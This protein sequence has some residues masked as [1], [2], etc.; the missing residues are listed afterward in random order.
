MPALTTLSILLLKL[1]NSSWLMPDMKSDFYLSFCISLDSFLVSV[2]VSTFESVS[3]SVLL[4][5]FVF[6]LCLTRF[7]ARS[8][9]FDSDY[10]I[11]F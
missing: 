3:E 1:L 8:R 4:S 6:D 2:L 7:S 10:A 11:D 9:R 5:E